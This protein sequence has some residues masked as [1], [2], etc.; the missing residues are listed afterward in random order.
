MRSL[1]PEQIIPEGVPALYRELITRCW[2]YKPEDRPTAE[3]ILLKIIPRIK[4]QHCPELVVK[5]ARPQLGMER[6]RAQAPLQS[7]PSP[8]AV[9]S[10]SDVVCHVS[11]T[12]SY[13][14]AHAHVDLLLVGV[15]QPARPVAALA[16]C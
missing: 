7:S 4:E 6:G 15:R 9:H 16:E 3:E 1:T 10:P 14:A 13:R 11:Y 8:G 12:A 2:A 5:Q